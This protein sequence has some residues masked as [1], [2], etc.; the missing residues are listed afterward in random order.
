[1]TIAESILRQGSYTDAVRD[2]STLSVIDN[3]KYTVK[4]VY[5]DNSVL[6]SVMGMLQTEESYAKEF[7]K[8]K[9]QKDV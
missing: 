7:E 9:S 5:P 6:I 1:M 4:L 2:C 3:N 8:L